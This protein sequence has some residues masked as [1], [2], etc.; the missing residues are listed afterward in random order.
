MSQFYPLPDWSL[1]RDEDP[2]ECPECDAPLI[3]RLC[4]CGWEYED[5][6]ETGGVWET[7]ADTEDDDVY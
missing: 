3:A 2:P 4:T 1:D 6:E 5:G 7:S